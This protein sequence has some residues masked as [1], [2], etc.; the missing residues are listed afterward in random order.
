MFPILVGST[1]SCSY[2]ETLA[3][4]GA[5]SFFLD[6][7]PPYLYVTD[8]GTSSDSVLKIYDVSVPA[9]P[10]LKSTTSLPTG[11]GAVHPR[12]HSLVGYGDVLLIPY[13]VSK[14]LA[15]WDVNDPSNP[16]L[17]G[18][19]SVS[20]KPNSVAAIGASACVGFNE[21]FLQTKSAEQVDISNPASPSVVANWAA[22]KLVLR[23]RAS[24]DHYFLGGQN[25][26]GGATHITAIRNSDF[27]VR[28]TGTDGVNI[29]GIGTGDIA[30]NAALTRAIGL[31]VGNATLDS[32][33]ISNPAAISLLQAANILG[34]AASSGC[35][36]WNENNNRAYVGR[37]GGASLQIDILNVSNLSSM[38]N[39]GSIST[40]AEAVTDIALIEDGCAGL[41]WAQGTG[42]AIHLVGTPP[43]S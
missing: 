40:S 5:G 4:S 13:R 42:A 29:A 38:T 25:S 17:L 18:S 10:V 11:S 37:G 24:T 22:S 14:V 30:L 39:A 36:S 6:C 23:V 7:V 19:V 8:E 32:W 9:T 41:A 34:A 2:D 21:N 1:Y 12:Y 31:N 15:I 16:S 35:V 3:V 27:V 43:T 28:S 26:S 20:F 33:D